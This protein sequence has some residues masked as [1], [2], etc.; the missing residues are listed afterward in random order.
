MDET[1]R[2]VHLTRRIP[3]D[4]ATNGGTGLLLDPASL[5]PDPPELFDAH[6]AV[7][8]DAL[9]EE[10]RPGVMAF[11]LSPPG[12]EGRLWL[13]ATET[14]RAGSIGRHGFADLYL[15]GRPGLSLRHCMVLVRRLEDAVRIHLVDLQSSG[16]IHLAGGEPLAAIDADGH[17]FL[18]APGVVLAFFPTGVP[19]PW[20][21]SAARPFATLPPVVPTRTQSPPRPIFDGSDRFHLS[22]AIVREGPVEIRP[23][24]LC[25]PDEVP[26]GQLVLS[27][28]TATQTLRIGYS[29]LDR[30][31]V[32]G[33]YDRCSGSRVLDDHRVSR[34]HALVFRRDH[35]LWIADV[36]STNGTFL[37]GEEI[38]CAPLRPGAA[39]ELGPVRAR[40]VGLD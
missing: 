11:V 7:I 33:R 40:W 22:T 6:H 36:G 31:V 23:E 24:A 34:V 12:I 3:R 39:V 30:G 2:I 29:A 38:R 17:L 19:L 21:P 4:E 9:S 28:D 37:D 8:A 5:W 15:P 1:T 32:L 14:L 35:T 25:L 26:A 13:Q 10:R 20:D 27:S 16:G 18:Q